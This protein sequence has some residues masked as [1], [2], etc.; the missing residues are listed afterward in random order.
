MSTDVNDFDMCIEYMHTFT[1]RSIYRDIYISYLYVYI[2]MLCMCVYC[3]YLLV[4]PFFLDWTSSKMVLPLVRGQKKKIRGSC[5]GDIS[6]S[7]RDL[8]K[9]VAVHGSFHFRI[10]GFGLSGK[11]RRVA[12]DEGGEG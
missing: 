1:H 8:S 2:Y 12:G 9:S 5:W 11:G 6:S 10:F 7:H 4:R 3:T